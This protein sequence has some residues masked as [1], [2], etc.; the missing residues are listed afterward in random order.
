VQL[1]GY[2]NNRLIEKLKDQRKTLLDKN[3]ELNEYKKYLEMRVMSRTAELKESYEQLVEEMT[4]RKRIEEQLTSRNKELDTF[5]YKASHDLKGSS[6][7]PDWGNQYS[8]A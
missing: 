2:K 7:F 6:G 5:V 8:Q 3:K 4:L 1:S